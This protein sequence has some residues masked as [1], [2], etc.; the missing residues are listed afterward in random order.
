MNR[1][2]FQAKKK[3]NAHVSLKE[4][5]IEIYGIKQIAFKIRDMN[6]RIRSLVIERGL[7][8]CRG[9]V[10]PGNIEPEIKE[11]TA[12]A[13]VEF[14]KLYK[15][16]EKFPFSRSTSVDHAYQTLKS[17]YEWRHDLE[18]QQRLGKDKDMEKTLEDVDSQIEGAECA[19]IEKV[20]AFDG[21]TLRVKTF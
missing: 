4:L 9:E 19:L 3:P 7:A 15:R 21:K 10:P 14:G 11:L 20:I 2:N 5:L 12:K 18:E 13:V 16:T 1:T 8:S 17:L 6:Y